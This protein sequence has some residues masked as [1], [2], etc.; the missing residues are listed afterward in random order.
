MR[1]MVRKIAVGFAGVYLL[2][3]AALLAVMRNPNAFG[4]VL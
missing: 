3:L 2:M 1:P 4:K